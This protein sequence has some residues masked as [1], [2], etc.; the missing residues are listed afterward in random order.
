M[1]IVSSQH[2]DPFTVLVEI[3]E[4]TRVHMFEFPREKVSSVSRF[5][6][7]KGLPR[8][9]SRGHNWKDE[10]Y[11]LVSRTLRDVHRLG[12][13][14]PA[15]SVLSGRTPGPLRPRRQVRCADTSSTT[16]ATSIIKADHEVETDM[17]STSTT[18]VTIS[19]TQERIT[20]ND[21]EGASEETFDSIYRP[22]YRISNSLSTH[23]D[24]RSVTT[25]QR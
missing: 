24:P 8:Q 18:P 9:L 14:R 23:S 16:E 13:Y 17:N 25:D 19:S 2:G 11:R 12:D 6:K 20:L 7:Q 5:L 15:P 3:K 21:S 1:K 4:E 10:H 22:S